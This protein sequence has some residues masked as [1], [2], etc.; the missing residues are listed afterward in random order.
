M[1]THPGPWPAGTPAWT[2]LTV[3]SV[4]AAREFYGPLLGWAFTVGAPE[5]GGYTTAT[6]AGHRVAGLGEPVGDADGT[7]QWCVYLATDDINATLARTGAAG[8]RIAVPATPIATMG[9]MA[10]VVDPTGAPF[11]VWQSSAHTGWD[12]VE[13][14]G[15]VAW[16][17]VMSDDQPL[18]LAFYRHVLELD[19]EDLSSDGFVYATLRRG[20]V[21]VA[22]VGRTDERAAWTVYFA[23]TDVDAAADQAVAG[24][25]TVLSGPSDSPFGRTARVRGPF[26]ETFA[27]IAPV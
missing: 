1:T 20:E 11:G 16:T 27:L 7:P 17:E 8:G 18:S 19:A 4:A 3:P 5:S 9:T 21:P 24:G 15:A 23:V 12:V 2:D 14:P 25:G 6:V 10:I 22:G 13:E 26:G